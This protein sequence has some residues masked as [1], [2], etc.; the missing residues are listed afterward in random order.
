MTPELRALLGDGREPDHEGVI[1]I[2]NAAPKASA[3]DPDVLRCKA[4]ALLSLDRFEEATAVFHDAG[5][6]LQDQA[7][8]E[9]AYALYKSGELERARDVAQGLDTRAAKHLVAQAVRELRSIR[10]YHERTWLTSLTVLPTRGLCDRAEALLGTA[11]L[12]G[13]RGER[14]PRQRPGDGRAARMDAARRTRP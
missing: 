3:K 7:P 8:L 9:H 10:R 12:G 5:R 6:S 11:G 4:V 14:R 1:N 2:C 13:R